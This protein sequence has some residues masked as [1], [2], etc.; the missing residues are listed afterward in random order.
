[1][2]TWTGIA[3]RACAAAFASFA[4]ACGDEGPTYQGGGRMLTPPGD[5]GAGYGVDAVDAA[6]GTVADASTDDGAPGAAA[7]VD[8]GAGD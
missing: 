5:M 8:G 2:L 3:R 6:P 1:M 4:L 7:F